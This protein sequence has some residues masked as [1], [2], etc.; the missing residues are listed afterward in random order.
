MIAGLFTLLP[1]RL[2]HEVLFSGLVFAEIA[3]RI[4]ATARDAPFWAWV[5]SAALVASGW[6]LNRRR[7]VRR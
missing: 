7:M 6:W 2:M 1:G 4:T 3:G 5:L